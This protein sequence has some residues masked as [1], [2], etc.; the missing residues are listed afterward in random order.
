MEDMFNMQAQMDQTQLTFMT[1]SYALMQ[2]VENLEMLVL[3]PDNKVYEPLPDFLK[4]DQMR[5][6]QVLINLIKNALKFSPKTM[7]RVF[8]SF[9]PEMQLLHVAVVDKGCGMRKE[10][11]EKLFQQFGK[12]EQADNINA[13]GIGMGLLICKRLV[14]ASN[15][16]IDIYSNGQ[17][18]GT[19]VQFTMSMKVC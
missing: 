6:T 19:I 2:A 10:D 12:L 1:I 4:G 7:V 3:M 17:G 5:L 15:G 13:E 14:E 18:K 9:D 8:S 11:K 16:G